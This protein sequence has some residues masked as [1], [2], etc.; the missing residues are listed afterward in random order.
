MYLWNNEHFNQYIDFKTYKLN[1]TYIYD[2][3]IYL[4]T[5]EILATFF[6][7]PETASIIHL[8]RTK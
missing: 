1:D 5:G 8:L 3:F 2:F 4:F 7:N 6:N